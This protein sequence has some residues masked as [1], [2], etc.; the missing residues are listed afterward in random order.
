MNRIWEVV[1][2][3]ARGQ[4][5]TL[6]AGIASVLGIAFLIEVS[7]GLPSQLAHLYYIPVVVSALLL[8][9]NRSLCITILAALAV[10]P[11]IDFIH[12]LLHQPSFFSGSNPWDLGS[13]GWILRPL[14][15]ISINFV[16]SL[17]SEERVGRIQER[18]RSES[19]AH[20]LLALNRIDRMILS[21]TSEAQCILEIARFTLELLNAKQAGLVTPQPSQRKLQTFSGFTRRSDGEVVPVESEH[22]TLGEG[23]SGWVM[24]H[25]GTATTRD[26]LADP[27]YQKLADIARSRGYRST[28]AAAIVLDGEILGA[29]VVSLEDVHDFTSDEIAAIERISDQAAVA[30]ANARQREALQNM[31]LETAM[32][33]SNVIETPDAYT[34]DHCLRLVEYSE[35]TARMLQLPGR[36]IDLIKL[37]AA[38]H[39]V[40]KI[41]VPDSILRKA[42]KLTPDEYA[43]I[44]QHCYAGG[45]IC[46][47]VPFLRSVQKIVYHHHEFFDGRGYPDGISGED[48]PLG[49]RIVSVADAYD[50]MTTDR[51]YRDA[52]PQDEAM[53]I[54]T[55]GAGSQWDPEIVR[56]FLH[57]IKSDFE[58]LRAA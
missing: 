8:T 52:L 4:V 49:A 54:L 6:S 56:C 39:D 5:L 15:F 13:S 35:L 17:V 34:G 18:S 55:R 31:G 27:R 23:V 40:G 9:P 3:T 38:L 19:R 46:K 29:L 43:Q 44:K 47:K 22:R 11:S 21:G 24:M 50:A 14:A 53:D 1:R 28:A 2:I 37:G 58:H 16:G 30:I 42:G 48:I 36:E 12:S 45:Q 41:I 7:G 57:G 51:P 20:E 25:G 10:S 32:V 26:V 33:L